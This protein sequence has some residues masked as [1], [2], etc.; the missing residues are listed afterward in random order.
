MNQAY[1]KPRCAVCGEALSFRHLHRVRSAGKNRK[2]CRVLI[3][4]YFAPSQ[5]IDFSGIEELAVKGKP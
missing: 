1:D 3:A 4:A 5:K 2:S